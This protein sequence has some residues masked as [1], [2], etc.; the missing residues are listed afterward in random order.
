MIELQVVQ[1]GNHHKEEGHLWP[2]EKNH[3]K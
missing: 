2:S 1:Q 3:I